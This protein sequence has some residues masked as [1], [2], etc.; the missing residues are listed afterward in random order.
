MYVSWRAG[1]TTLFLLGS[2]SPHRLFTNSSTDIL[3]L[4]IEVHKTVHIPFKEQSEE[5]A[6]QRNARSS[7]YKGQSDSFRH[8]RGQAHLL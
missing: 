7:L 5:N 1:T 2:Y 3:L 6:Q 4:H 8:S